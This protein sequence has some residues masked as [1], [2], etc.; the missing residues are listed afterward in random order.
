MITTRDIYWGLFAVWRLAHLDKSGM[1]YIDT[2]I[3]GFWKSFFAAAI[4]LPGFA[5]LQ[6]LALVT[7]PNAAPASPWPRVVVLFAIAYVIRWVAFPLAMTGV[8]EILDRRERY[9]PTMVA[10]NWSSVVQIAV[11]LPAGVVV[12][13]AGGGPIS[14]LDLVV[15]IGILVY[16]WFIIR[17]TLDVPGPTAGALVALDFVL[18][19]LIT[20]TTLLM[21]G[22]AAA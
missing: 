1:Q 5:A 17:T 12:A 21:V 13:A 10:Y 19:L 15:M 7:I 8:A 14:L 20:G 16:L 6:A 9:I 2:T 11:A 3:E 22:L 18:N 4:T